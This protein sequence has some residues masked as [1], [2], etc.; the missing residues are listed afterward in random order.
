MGYL[1]CLAARMVITVRCGGDWDS[2]CSMTDWTFS[3]Y[4]HIELIIKGRCLLRTLSLSKT[5]KISTFVC[6]FQL[7]TLNKKPNYRGV[8]IG[9]P[10]NILF[11]LETIF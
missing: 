5:V 9:T 1:Q 6:V 10:T 8:P 2:D 7:G 4:P 11:Q 3:D